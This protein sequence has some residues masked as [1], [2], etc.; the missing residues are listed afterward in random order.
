M[1]SQML[2]AMLSG[3]LLGLGLCLVLFR[4]PFMRGPDFS[5]RI[6]PQMRPSAAQSRLLLRV[7]APGSMLG[8]LERFLRG[9]LARAGVRFPG[10]GSGNA[11]LALRLGQAGRAQ[12]PLEFR[13]E[14]LL[15][16][17]V[18]FGVAASISVF[19]A[20]GRTSSPLLPAV[21]SLGAA[22]FGY[23][24]RDHLLSQQIKRRERKMLNEFP[25]LAELMALAVGAG[26]SAAGAL[27]R[28]CRASSGELS[29]EF[30]RILNRTRSGTPLIEALAEFSART[31]AMPLV[32]FTDGLAVAIQRGTPLADVLRAQAQD[33]RDLAKREL[34]ESAGKKEIAMM[35]PVVFGILPLTVLFAAFPGF[36]LLSFGL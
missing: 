23:L 4:A 32:R 16:A 18:G 7:D 14:Q 17:G 31:T 33:V 3:A 6:E 24:L 28:V 15:W 8:P 30:E 13:A 29:S 5:E 34:M 20:I 27:E 2:P 10:I 35:I 22:C 19:W 36:H 25:A 12:S 1:S 11:N 21:V 26:E 9:G